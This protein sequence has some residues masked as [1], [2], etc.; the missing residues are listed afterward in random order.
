[1][2]APEG[3]VGTTAGEVNADALDLKANP[4]ADLDEPDAKRIEWH[5]SNVPVGK[6]APDSIEQVVDSGVE[7]QSD[8]VDPEGM[9]GGPA[10][11][12]GISGQSAGWTWCARHGNRRLASPDRDGA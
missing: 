11:E 3:S 9:V 5:A 12:I 4:A 1:M 10:G 8:L 7:Q 6:P 2:E